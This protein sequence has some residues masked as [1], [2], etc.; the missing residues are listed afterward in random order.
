MPRQAVLKDSNKL[1]MRIS[2]E[3]W[4]AVCGFFTSSA[5]VAG[6]LIR[7]IR[8]QCLNSLTSRSRDRLRTHRGYILLV[9]IFRI[10]LGALE[11][12]DREE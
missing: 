4:I 9:G 3:R 11:S 8:L 5:R 6:H 12:E 10:Q 2:R 1:F 7:P